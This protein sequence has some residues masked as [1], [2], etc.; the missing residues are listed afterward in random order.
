[1]MSYKELII[2]GLRLALT[3]KTEWKNYFAAVWPWG[4]S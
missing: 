4:N 1:M 3:R 2:A